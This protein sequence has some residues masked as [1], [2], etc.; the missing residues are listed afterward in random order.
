MDYAM[1]YEPGNEFIMEWRE[2]ISVYA[3][4]W[5]SAGRYFL[6]SS[7]NIADPGDSQSSGEIL[8]SFWAKRSVDVLPWIP[9]TVSAVALRLSEL[10]AS[11]IYVK[12]SQR[13]LS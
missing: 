10:D 6:S 8:S 4:A 11:T 12:P 9:R 13:N 1:C 2:D 3:S 5:T 7:L